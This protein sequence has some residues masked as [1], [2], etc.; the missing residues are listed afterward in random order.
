V[1][2]WKPA[3]IS[4]RLLLRLTWVVIGALIVLAPGRPGLA[5]A[6]S[7]RDDL[8]RLDGF[9]TTLSRSRAETLAAGAS[10]GGQVPLIPGT[11]TVLRSAIIL[12]QLTLSS[13]DSPACN[14]EPTCSRFAQE[15]IRIRGPILGSLM[16]SDRLQ[17]C[18]GA[19]RRYY[20][21]DPVTFRALDPV[22]P[23][24]HPSHQPGWPTP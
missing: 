22:R 13:Q 7:L 24:S 11:R 14:Y 17:R 20:P 12:Y 9:A 10:S 19:A 3:R 1:T 8:G 15:A 16:A 6:G 5:T 18:I 2:H 21:T 23:S 4:C